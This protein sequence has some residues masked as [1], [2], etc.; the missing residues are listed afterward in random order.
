MF[1]VTSV[2]RQK[3]NPKRFNIFLDGVFAF[4][5]DADTVV[6]FRLIEGKE[7]DSESLQKVLM[8]TEVGVLMDRMYGLFGRRARS[9]QEIRNYLRELSF[10]RK[11]KDKEE[12]SGVVVESLI[13]RLKQKGLLNDEEF[14][15][16]WVQARQKNKFKGKNAI[17][18]E[19]YQ[20]GIDRDMINEVISDQTS[21]INEKDLATQ[22]L[23]KKM[24]SWK[25]L[26]EVDLKKKA[27][28]FLM[29]RGFDYEVIKEVVRNVKKD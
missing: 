15:K 25:N 12:I 8:E 26:A 21:D 22:A 2:E 17:K 9:E 20:K 19:L 6:N 23:E 7:V 4:G 18:A 10:K 3:K 5:A 16:S 29:R 27:Y 13:E 11:I 14:A 1:K 24:K 28:E